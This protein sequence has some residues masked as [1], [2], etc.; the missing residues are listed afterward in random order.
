MQCNFG[1]L[2]VKIFRMAKKY[3]E[4]PQVQDA[5]KRASIR[6]LLPQKTVVVIDDDKT[7]NSLVNLYEPLLAYLT[8]EYSVLWTR[9]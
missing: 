5:L 2:D 3:Y 7:I 4:G 1:C 9:F 6:D 8:K